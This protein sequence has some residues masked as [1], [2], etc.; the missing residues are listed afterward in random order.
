MLSSWARAGWRGPRDLL[1]LTTQANTLRPWHLGAACAILPTVRLSSLDR[2]DLG[3][4]GVA[5]LA[6][7]SRW[8]L[9]SDLP[10]TGDE[11]SNLEPLFWQDW[12]L[13]REAASSP[14][15]F[16]GL[17]HATAL[18]P[19]SV[20]VMRAPAALFGLLLIGLVYRLL[21]RLSSPEVALAGAALV[22]CQALEVRLGVEQKA[23]T[24]WLC[25]LLAT[26]SWA[27]RALDGRPYA[28]LWFAFWL[29]VA[30]LTHHLTW[31]TIAGWSVF[32]LWR[33]PGSRRALILAIVPAILLAA[34]WLWRAFSAPHLAAEGP[35]LLQDARWPL[36]AAHALMID[37]EGLG[38]TL[39]LAAGVGAARPR[40]TQSKLLLAGLAGAAVGVLI[41]GQGST[42]RARFFAPVWPFAILW[43]GATLPR[44]T[45]AWR[46]RTRWLV[47]A[48]VLTAL[49]SGATTWKSLLDDAHN[50]WPKRIVTVDNTMPGPAPPLTVLH[51]SW[52]LHATA[53]ERSGRRTH[54]WL[55]APPAPLDVAMRDDGRLWGGFDRALTGSDLAALLAQHHRLQVVLLPTHD[56][57]ADFASAARWLGE[58]CAKVDG[59]GGEASQRPSVWRCG[60]VAERDPARY[61]ASE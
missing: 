12:T 35:G 18:A 59:F 38:A 10:L 53:W 39:L 16:R 5:L 8:L 31:L 3:A 11:A 50:N 58:R 33:V 25:A 6:L 20:L 54:D 24:L 15:L 46:R 27:G 51:P 21:R 60:G 56:V 34:P 32:V 26:W 14:P 41:L 9:L 52:L 45:G 36:R 44:D 55:Q 2:Y 23:Y 47:A 1:V 48:A 30:A 40:S 7:A 19:E 37:G 13:G 49:G 43:A 4:L 42:P 22:A 17:I 61:H 28:W 29:M 57:T